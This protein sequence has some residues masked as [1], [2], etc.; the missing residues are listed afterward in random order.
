MVYQKLQSGDIVDVVAPSYGRDIDL[1]SI[2]QVI[3]NMGF[4][5]RIPDNM[6]VKGADLFCANT[7]EVRFEQLKQAIFAEDSKIIWAFRGGY[8]AARLIPKLLELPCPA[9]PKIFIGH[10]DM[11]VFHIFFTQQYGW[12]TIHGRTIS[13]FVARNTPPEEVEN[14][15]DIL[16][17]RKPTTILKGLKPLNK[18]AKASQSIEA[19]IIGG[20]ISL[21][22]TSIGTDWQLNSA[23]KIVLLEDVD[24]R[25]Y[26]IDRML[27]H[28][29]QAKILKQARAIIVG[30]IICGKEADGSQLCTDAIQR[31]AES[32]NIPVISCPQV[33]HGDHNWPVPMNM[34]A[35][36]VLGEVPTLEIETF[37]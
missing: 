9:K 14:T 34:T 37:G 36:L 26:R 4:V 3:R 11:T 31:W 7:D 17:A 20:C 16:F 29:M 27:E 21:I 19:K 32:I 30:D 8:G 18:A 2:A 10:S 13:E 12:S 28:I 33:G 5:P 35:R 1:N 6:I 22:Q 15:L 25:G 24:E 23:G